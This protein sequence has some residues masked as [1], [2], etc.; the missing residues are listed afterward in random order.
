MMKTI[1]LINISVPRF[2]N[3][4]NIVNNLSQQDREKLFNLPLNHSIFI[5]GP[6]Y[7][8][9]SLMNTSVITCVKTWGA[10]S[11]MIKVFQC[12]NPLY[13]AYQDIDMIQMQGVNNC[14]VIK[15][16]Q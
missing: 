11:S 8:N 10:G 12:T 7:G 1:V 5:E 15:V 13:Y 2:S 16:F 6:N 4:Q 3:N 14:V 9:Y